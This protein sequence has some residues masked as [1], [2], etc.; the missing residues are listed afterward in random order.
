MLV[1]LLDS[2]PKIT[3]KG[4]IFNRNYK[5]EKFWPEIEMNSEPKNLFTI[6]KNNTLSSRLVRETEKTD[7]GKCEVSESSLRKILNAITD[8]TLF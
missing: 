2:H 7:A 5:F 8:G 6:E 1:S 4:E 3:C